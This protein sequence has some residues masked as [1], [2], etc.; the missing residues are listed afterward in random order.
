MAEE[1]K[2]S[3]LH[4]AAQKLGHEGG[5]KGGPAR[6]R[7]LT[8]AQR[9]EIARAGGKA[10]AAKER[11]EHKLKSQNRKPKEAKAPKTKPKQK[12]KEKAKAKDQD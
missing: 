4:D 12:T 5:I 9:E 6:A 8:Q 7:K 2:N 11:M 1:S 10:K 3:D